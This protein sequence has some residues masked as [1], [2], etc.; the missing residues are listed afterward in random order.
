METKTDNRVSV[1]WRKRPLDE[2][3]LSLE[4]LRAAVAARKDRS[5]AYI[6]SSKQVRAYGTEEGELVLGTSK[7]VKFFT[8]WSFG[9]LAQLVHAPAGYLK[10]L[11]ARLAA[12]CVNYGIDHSERLEQ[13]LLV[14]NEGDRLRALTSTSYGRIW[15]LQVVEAVMRVNERSG[16]IWKIPAASYATTNPLRATTLYASDRDV[17]IFLVDDKHPIE[18]DGQQFYR[19]FY[20]GNSETGAALYLVSFFLYERVCDNRIIWGIK[21]QVSLKIKHSSGAPERFLHEGNQALNEYTNAETRPLIERIQRAKRIELGKNE[22][23]VREFLQKRGLTLVQ[24]NRAIEYAKAE[25]GDFRSAWQVVQ[26]VTASARAIGNT[27]LRLGLE[28]RAGKILD[29]VTA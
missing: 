13:M 10:T 24:S 28:V 3:F 15:D 21:D 19:G 18:I 23:E 5:E 16:G 2:R 20:V 29:A 25:E 22:D 7:G 1:E 4:D 8:N 9:Q 17:F 26:G 27:D 11:D 14:D 12:D 6:E